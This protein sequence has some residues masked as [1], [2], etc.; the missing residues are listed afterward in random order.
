MLAS[1]RSVEHLS[2][3]QSNHSLQSYTYRPGPGSYY[4]HFSG[5]EFASALAFDTLQGMRTAGQFKKRI[6]QSLR[7]RL[8]HFVTDV[9][10]IILAVSAL[11]GAV[12]Y[13]FTP[14]SDATAMQALIFINSAVVLIMIV[15]NHR[16]NINSEA[17]TVLIEEPSQRSRSKG[18]LS[19]TGRNFNRFLKLLRFVLSILFAMGAVQ[20]ASRYR[21]TN[22]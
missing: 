7:N 9:Y 3:S 13:G 10:W 19:A 15:I 8:F 18:C 20:L 2:I 1:C 5:L 16:A 6:Q 22:P 14:N 12:G 4:N 21:F 11:I 17:E